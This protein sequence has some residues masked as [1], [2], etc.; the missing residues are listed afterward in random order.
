MALLAA[1]ASLNLVG[2]AARDAM[3]PRLR[4]MMGDA[5]VRE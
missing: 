4:G 1:L 2:D 3:D 5:S